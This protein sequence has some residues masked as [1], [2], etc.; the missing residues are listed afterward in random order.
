MDPKIYDRNTAVPYRTV[1]VVLLDCSGH[2]RLALAEAEGLRR[3]DPH[4]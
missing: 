2:L 4:A 1:C 3:D